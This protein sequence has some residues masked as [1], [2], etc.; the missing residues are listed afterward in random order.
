MRTFLLSIALLFTSLLPAQ[1][2]AVQPR[3]GDLLFVTADRTGL[4]GAIH[5][6]TASAGALSYDHVAL[7]AHDAD[8]AVVLHADEKGSREQ[9][10]PEFLAEAAAKGR[11]V[12]LYRLKAPQ[13]PTIAGAIARARTMLGKPYNATYVQDEGSYYCSDFIERAFRPDAVFQTQPMNFR[14]LQTGEMPAYWVEFY[15]SRG[16]QVPQDA[17]GTNPNDMSRAPVLVSVGILH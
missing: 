14:N 2:H 4:S 5:D 15:G 12:V 3:D 6:A 16:M 7:V 11:T 1:A 9:P 10:L 17:P 13:H 8:A